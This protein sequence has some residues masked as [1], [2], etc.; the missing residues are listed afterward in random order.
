M[1]VK[2]YRNKVIE[3]AAKA[4]LFY[5]LCIFRSPISGIE[6]RVA[7]FEDVS[8]AVIFSNELIK[9]YTKFKY[10]FE[11]SSNVNIINYRTDDFF[12]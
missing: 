6:R 1:L 11:I 9:T 2:E 10:P 4:N 12:E 8:E 5:V 7:Y 3:I